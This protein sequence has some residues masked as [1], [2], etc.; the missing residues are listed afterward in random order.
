MHFLNT[1][2]SPLSD[3]IQAQG[4]TI[5]K[6]IGDSIMAFWNAP[7]R[8]ENHAAMACA[9]GLKML[10]VVDQLNAEDAFGFKARNFKTQ[11]VQ[12]GIGL[13]TGEACVGNMGSSRRFNYSVIGDAVNVASRIESSCKSVGADL[14]VSEDTRIKAPDFAYLEAGAI[15]LKG[16]SRPVKLFALVGDLELRRS[17]AFR[18]LE[19]HHMALMDALDKGKAGEAAAAL[20]AC[21][22]AAPP[23]LEAFYDRLAERLERL[24]AEMA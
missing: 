24:E 5:D 3:A 2:L 13:N 4:G 9:A 18:K 19:L 10:D 11:T 12:I 22:E 20:A 6:Y 7:V 21:R 15:P 1:L 17:D 23:E 16:K 14:V 8:M